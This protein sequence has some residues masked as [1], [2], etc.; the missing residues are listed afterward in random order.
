MVYFL[1]EEPFEPQPVREATKAVAVRID[2]IFFEIFINPPYVCVS[3][4][5]SY[6]SGGKKRCQEKRNAGDICK[7][8]CGGIFE[9]NIVRDTKIMLLEVKRQYC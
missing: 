1:E 6:Y 9:R 2:T 5:H 7:T 8:E 4:C 3:M